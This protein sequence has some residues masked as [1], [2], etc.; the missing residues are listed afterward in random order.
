M[1]LWL[2]SGCHCPID[3][4]WG[5]TQMGQKKRGKD[6]S[7]IECCLPCPIPDTS[8][9]CGCFAPHSLVLVVLVGCTFGFGFGSLRRSH[10]VAWYGHELTVQ[11][12]LASNSQSSC[13]SLPSIQA[14]ITMAVFC[15]ILLEETRINIHLYHIWQG[16]LPRAGVTQRQLQDHKG[17][18]SI[19]DDS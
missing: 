4:R 3:P 14:Y 10:Y 5:R 6:P 18:R 16:F 19:S 13:F 1:L 11:Y 12:I 2:T 15:P 7:L 17:H 9:H 8:K